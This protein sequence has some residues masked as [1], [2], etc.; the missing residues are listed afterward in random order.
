MSVLEALRHR[1]RLRPQAEA[2]LDR[3]GKWTCDDLWIRLQ[4]LATALQRMQVHRVSSSLGNGADA[5]LIDLALRQIGAIHLPLP[6]FFSAAQRAHAESSAG[7]DHRVSSEPQAGAVSLIDGLWIA[8][9]QSHANRP[10]L[11]A[12][13]ALITFTSGST[14]TPKGVCLSAAHLDDVAAAVVDALAGNTPQRHLSLL[15]LSLLLEQ[16]AGVGAALLSGATV[17]LPDLASCGL[18]GAALVDAAE[19]AAAIERWQPESTILVPQLLQAWLQGIALG[20]RMPATMRFVAVG[21]A[22]V[23]PGLLAA[24]ADAGVPLYQGYG[25]S[26]CSSVVSLN[27]PDANRVGSVGQALGHARIRVADD[28]EILVEGNVLLG[29]VGEQPYAGSVYATGDCGRLD[30]DGYLYIDGRKRDVFIT[31]FGRN[32]SPE[33]VESELCQ[34]PLIAQAYVDGEGRAGNCAVIVARGVQL[35]ARL[36]AAIAEVN[37]GLPD[38]ARVSRYLLVDEPFSAANGLLTGNGRVRRSAIRARYGAALDALYQPSSQTEELPC[39]S[40]TS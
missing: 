6:G 3:R 26:E 19:L 2:V 37:G 17:L 24:A 12:G 10:A 32:V 13:T 36:D 15:P 35:R 22:R 33:W 23:A 20:A 16:I 31:A 8:A 18:R 27:R 4:Q 1:A 39:L 21:G 34:H 38:Y 28:G 29:Y 7:A 14:G 11:P 5:V 9:L 30:A 25:L 40:M